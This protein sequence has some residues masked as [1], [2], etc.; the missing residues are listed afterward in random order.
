G[1]AGII[2][3]LLAM[4]HETLPAT[5]HAEEPSAEVDW[6]VGAVGLRTESRP[7]SA[8]VRPR[9]AGVSAFGVSGTIAHVILEEP[10][11]AEPASV[12]VAHLPVVP[13][14]LSGRTPV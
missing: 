5:L 9:R 2:K 14:L 13:V 11:V 3:M 10:P 1:V 6:S 8:G 7:W 12:P 4:R